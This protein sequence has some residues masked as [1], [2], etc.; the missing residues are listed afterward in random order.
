ME[1][2]DL[3]L[4]QLREAPWNP[5]RMDPT[6]RDRLRE[7]LT[8][9]GLVSNLVVRPLRPGS[10]Q[11]L[12]EGGYEVLSGNQRLEALRELGLDSV[13]CVVVDLGDASARLLAQTLNR[14][15]GEDEPGLKVELLRDLLEQLPQEEVLSLLPESAEGLAALGSLNQQDLATELRNWDRAKQARLRHLTFQLTHSQLATIE[16]A[17]AVALIEVRDPDQNNPNPRGNALFRVCQSYLNS[18]R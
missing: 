18:R 5:N 17:L 11:A 14:V 12:P 4:E 8:R 1:V 7:S 2:I 13:P 16:Q 9:F 3:S 10:G 6:T 15:M